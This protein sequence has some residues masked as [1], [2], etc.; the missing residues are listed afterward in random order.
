MAQTVKKYIEFLETLDP[1]ELILIPMIWD[2]TFAEDWADV[3]LTDKAWQQ[4]IDVV[5]NT[6]GF[7]GYLVDMITDVL[8]DKGKSRESE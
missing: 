5:E 3:D 1:E 8:Y 6:D 2:K 7:T 4:V